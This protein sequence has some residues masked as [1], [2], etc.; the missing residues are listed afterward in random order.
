MEI[1]DTYIK[2]EV[3]EMLREMQQETCDCI[4]FIVGTVFQL[5]VVDELLGK[6]ISDLGGESIDYK[7]V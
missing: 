4:G 7:V 5:W 3:I 1:K 6:R 2:E